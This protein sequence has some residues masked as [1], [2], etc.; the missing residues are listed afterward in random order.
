MEGSTTGVQA[1]ELEAL[2]DIRSLLKPRR[3][4]SEGAG[5]AVEKGAI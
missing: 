3:A 1:V 4:V 2:A 5:S